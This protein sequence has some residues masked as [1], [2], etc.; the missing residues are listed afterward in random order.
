MKDKLAEFYKCALQ[1]NTY[2]YIKYRG[3]EHTFSEDEYNNAILK[4]CIEKDI[5]IVGLADHGDISKQQN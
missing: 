1:V 3:Q 2:D 4:N 5:K